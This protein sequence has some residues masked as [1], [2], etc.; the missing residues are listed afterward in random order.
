MIRRVFKDKPKPKPGPKPGP[1]PT[2]SRPVPVWSRR[3]PVP[4]Q[5]DG[6]TTVKMVGRRLQ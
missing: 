4:G 1:R 3:P 6:T 2:R 5:Q